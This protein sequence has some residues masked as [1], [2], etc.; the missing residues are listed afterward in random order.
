[1]KRRRRVYQLRVVAIFGKYSYHGRAFE[2]GEGRALWA[3]LRR[4][5]GTVRRARARQLGAWRAQL[6]RLA[7]LSTR[8]A[9]HPDARD[10]ARDMLA[11]L[12][13]RPGDVRTLSGIGARASL[14]GT[15][16]QWAAP[17]LTWPFS[18]RV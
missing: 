5:R 10:V 6:Y 17:L 16:W 8:R 15:Y 7:Q 4:R 14:G 1:M 12:S 13:S 18:S 2:A 3:H 9:T 11:T